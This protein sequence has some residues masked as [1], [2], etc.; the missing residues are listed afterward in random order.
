[1]RRLAHPLIVLGIRKSNMEMQRSIFV[2]AA[3]RSFLE[4]S[5]VRHI[6]VNPE[7]K[8]KLL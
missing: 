6:N 8:T 1:M 7:I 5:I 4:T 3:R 2:F